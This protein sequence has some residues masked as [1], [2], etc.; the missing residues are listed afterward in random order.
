[1][2]PC[3]NEQIVGPQQVS[4]APNALSDADLTQV[5]ELD[6][7]IDDI[8][9]LDH[10]HVPIARAGPG[11]SAG[12]GEPLADLNEIAETVHGV[13]LAVAPHKVNTSLCYYVST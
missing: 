6:M 8:G 7:V 1:M 4:L 12:N 11:G 2:R 3:R 5:L 13:T 9:A 10:V